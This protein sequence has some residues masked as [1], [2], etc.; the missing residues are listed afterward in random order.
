MSRGFLKCCGCLC[1]CCLVCTN[2]AAIIIGAI[3]LLLGAVLTFGVRIIVNSL[4]SM[5]SSMTSSITSS[6]KSSLNVD[7]DIVSLLGNLS[8]ITGPL[9]WSFLV[10][11]VLVIVLSCCGCCGACC[12]VKGCLIIYA[13]VVSLVLIGQITVVCIWFSSNNLFKANAKAAMENSIKEY[14]GLN[15]KN[16][17][18]L[19]QNL[20]QIFIGCCG[21]TNGTD[22]QLLSTKWNREYTISE[23]GYNFTFNLTYPETCCKFNLSSFK[24]LDNYCPYNKTNP[25]TSNYQVG[26]Y[27]ATFYYLEQYLQFN[28]LFYGM[29]AVLAVQALLVAG[30]VFILADDTKNNNKVV[31]A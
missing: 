18:S 12:T 16:I 13:A 20:I 5:I 24:P 25:Q 27:N 15:S 19:L 3:L 10:I 31:P 7:I 1:K 2:I 23:S 6:L 8:E 29:A 9:G 11:G 30:A 26:C 21:V 22:F 28:Y 4:S 14:T 17:Q